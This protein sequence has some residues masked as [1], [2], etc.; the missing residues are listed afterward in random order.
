MGMTQ[1]S[2]PY[3]QRL[4]A[5]A[6]ANGAAVT[7]PRSETLRV[8]YSPTLSIYSSPTLRHYHF[9]CQCA[10][11]P[12]PGVSQH[13]AFALPQFR[14]QV[15]L[16]TGQH[17]RTVC[18]SNTMGGKLLDHAKRKLPAISQPPPKAL[19]V[20]LTAVSDRYSTPRVRTRLLKESLDFLFQ[21]QRSAP[22]TLRLSILAFL[23]IAMRESAQ[24]TRQLG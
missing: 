2:I 3:P 4:A 14:R 19:C 11:R 23:L 6:L 18:F 8:R 20:A 21:L 5:R 9:S 15:D 17:C 24:I 10:V 7:T 16:H 12:I 22:G 13:T 1:T